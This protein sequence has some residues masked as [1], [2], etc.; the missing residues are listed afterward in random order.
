MAKVLAVDLDGTLFYPKRRKSLITT[1]NVQFIRDFVD[2]GNRV[3][4][5]TSRSRDFAEFTAVKIERGIDFVCSNGAQIVLD[6]ELVFDETLRQ[7][8]AQALFEDMVTF[9]HQ[10]LAWFLD[11]KRYQNLLYNNGTSWFVQQFFKYYYKSQG[12]YQQAYLA[13]ND[14]FLSELKKG[15]IYRLLLYFGLGRKRVN[16]AKEVNKHIREHYPDFESSWINTIVEVAPRQCN[17]ATALEFIIKRQGID[18]GDVHVVGDSGN[19]ISM[20]QAF[21]DHSYCMAHAHLSVKKFA[22]HIIKRVHH[23]RTV[24]L[25]KEVTP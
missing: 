3:I 25:D 8:Q 17:K 13:D 10:P 11:S 7:G 9:H 4:F 15:R 18:R 24:L 12:V 2:A 1:A 21:K 23:L 19:D 5:V 22:R 14:I 16:I 6:G 20:F